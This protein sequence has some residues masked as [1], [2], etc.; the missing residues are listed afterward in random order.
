MNLIT[1]I[2]NKNIRLIIWCEI[3]IDETI[4]MLHNIRKYLFAYILDCYVFNLIIASFN[5]NIHTIT[6]T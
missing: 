6:D 2:C 4:Y 3:F 5:S 1:F